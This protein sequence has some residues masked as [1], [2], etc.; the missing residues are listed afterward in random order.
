MAIN[1]RTIVLR[2][3]LLLLIG[4]QATVFFAGYGWFRAV[5]RHGLVSAVHRVVLSRWPLPVLYLGNLRPTLI[6]S[7]INVTFSGRCFPMPE[8]T[9]QIEFQM[10]SAARPDR[11]SFLVV[12]GRLGPNSILRRTPLIWEKTHAAGDITVHPP[13]ARAGNISGIGRV[14]GTLAIACR[15]YWGPQ[16]L[17]HRNA[18]VGRL[19]VAS[20]TKDIHVRIVVS[21][22]VLVPEQFLVYPGAYAGATPPILC[23]D[24]VGST[25]LRAGYQSI[26]YE[27][28]SPRA[29]RISARIL[30]AAGCWPWTVDYVIQ[31]ARARLDHFSQE[32]VFLAEAGDPPAAR[33][34][35]APR[36][37]LLTMAVAASGM[38][39]GWGSSLVRADLRDG[40]L[41]SV[42]Y[43]ANPAR[44]ERS[45]SELWYYF[46]R[47]G[48]HRGDV[49]IGDRRAEI[50]KWPVIQRAA[51]AAGALGWPTRRSS[52]AVSRWPT[53][54]NG[55]Q[56]RK[57][58]M[59]Q[60]N[61]NP[62]GN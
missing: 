18:A 47:A 43:A 54:S 7:A 44:D 53:S 22:A 9:R 15:V 49:I 34:R 23:T 57:P 6:P 13:A 59:G 8:A 51:A 39:R 30:R 12:T 20:R 29:R 19:I 40:R 45:Y 1:L 41:Y 14:A 4:A 61:N 10:F 3:S 50:M 35:Q 5:S 62:G 52:P 28:A 2:R 32:Q 60:K 46:D 37:L 36:R 55:P 42:S 17:G 26:F 31:A 56:K 38:R 58:R 16:S 33:L 24:W 25:R 21:N 27:W 48:L 11:N